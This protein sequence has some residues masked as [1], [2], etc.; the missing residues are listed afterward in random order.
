MVIVWRDVVGGGDVEMLE[1][2]AERWKWM[3]GWLRAAS[4]KEGRARKL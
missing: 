4:M 2:D 3:A 1:R